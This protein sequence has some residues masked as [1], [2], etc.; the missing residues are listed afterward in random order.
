MKKKEGLI[1]KKFLAEEKQQWGKGT[2]IC[3]SWAEFEKLSE[4]TPEGFVSP[5]GAAD[6]LGVSRVYINQLEKEGKIRA[7]RIIVD[8]KL[9]GSEPFWVRVFMP[10]KNVFIMIPSE[11]IAKIKEEMI[12]KAEAKIKK[13]RGKK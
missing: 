5:G 6:A 1:D 2:V 10:T 9:K 13:L 12:N 8:D 11:D 4:E 7:Y 3:H